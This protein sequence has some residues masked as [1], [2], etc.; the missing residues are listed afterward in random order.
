M[1]VQWIPS[2]MRSKGN[3]LA[4]MEAKRQTKLPPS[5]EHAN[6]QTLS[7]A[8]R[9]I[10]GMKDNAWK[11]EWEKGGNTTAAKTYLDLT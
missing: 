9:K 4:D 1:T 3:E 6:Y 2:H 11:L 8:K 5:A 10:R 7:S